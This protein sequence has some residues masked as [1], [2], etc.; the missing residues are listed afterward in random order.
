MAGRAGAS[1]SADAPALRPEPVCLDPLPALGWRVWERELQDRQLLTIA[2]PS[3]DD[4][5]VVTIASEIQL[6]D[7]DV[8]AEHRSIERQRDALEGCHLLFFAVGVDGRLLYECLQ[9]GSRQA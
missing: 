7:R 3:T 5:D 1:R 6:L 9:L 2:P 8:H 4:G